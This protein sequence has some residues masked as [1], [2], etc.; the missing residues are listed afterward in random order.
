MDD[1]DP[2][3]LD[4]ASQIENDVRKLEQHSKHTG[5]IRKN[6]VSKLAL[7]VDAMII[8]T[9]TDKASMI[10]AKM[11]VVNTLLK[12]I[13]DSDNQKIDIIRLKQKVKSDN[14]QESTVKMISDTVTQF[15]KRI[16][17]KITLNQSNPG[18]PIDDSADKALDKAVTDSGVEVLETEL[19]FTTKSAKDIEME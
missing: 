8:D 12:A 10:E 19:A 6:I 16:D 4:I 15:M 17:M 5:S 1:M 7:T 13:S 9:N 3:T 2:E 18:G 11:N 14:V